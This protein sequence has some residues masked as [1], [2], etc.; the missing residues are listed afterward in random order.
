MPEIT[1]KDAV[2]EALSKVE[3]DP[4]IA[5]VYAVLAVAFA[6]AEPKQATASFSYSEL[7]KRD[8]ETIKLSTKALTTRFHK[9]AGVK[10][11]T[12]EDLTK[13]T[14]SEF[15]RTDNIGDKITREIGAWLTSNGL[16]FKRR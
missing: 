5:L 15:S 10:A 2:S 16:S 7:L 9:H 13:M 14:Q 12:V 4:E 1:Y 6:L 8:I 3:S 11:K